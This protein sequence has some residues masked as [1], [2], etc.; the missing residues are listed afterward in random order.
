MTLRYALPPLWASVPQSIP[1]SGGLWKLWVK[2][3]QE[4]QG[5]QGHPCLLLLLFPL[6]LLLFP[7]GPDVL[8]KSPPPLPLLQPHTNA[9]KTF[10]FLVTGVQAP[11][12][13]KKRDRA[14]L[15]LAAALGLLH[16]PLPASVNSCL[17]LYGY[18]GGPGPGRSPLI[19]GFWEGRRTP[20][21]GMGEVLRKLGPN[22]KWRS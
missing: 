9:S 12:V 11:V 3:P 15:N 18:H 16:W 14:T 20:K 13:S 21:R 6:L 4:A 10:A 1:Y 5:W 22:G 8:R 17:T 7:L 19:T 2:K